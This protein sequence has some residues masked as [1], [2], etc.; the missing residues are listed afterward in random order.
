MKVPSLN[1]GNLSARLPIVQGGMGVGI[2]MS[3]LAGAVARAG[4]I[5]VISAVGLGFYRPD[6]NVDKV[7]A[8]IQ[9]LHDQIKLAREK[10]RGG[11]IG[12][13][14]M[15]AISE[16]DDLV[17]ASIEAG[18]DIIF[19][20]AGLPTDLPKL[21]EG[22]KIKLAPIISSAKA[23]SVICRAWTKRYNYTPDAIVL[24]G[25]LAGGHLGF[26]IDELE[27]AD[28]HTLDTLLKEVLEAVKP[29]EEAAG[30]SIPIIAG[31]G[32]WDGKDIAKLLTSGAA[33]VQ[34]ATRFVTTEECDASD[35]F[36]KAYLAAQSP[37]DLMLIKSPVGL[38]GRALRNSFLERVS[39]GET[40]PTRCSYNCLKTCKPREAPYCIA[41]VLINAQKGQLEDGFAFAGANAW[42]CQEIVAVQ[43]L[44]DQLEK[45]TEQELNNLENK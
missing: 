40:I 37:D 29:F 42:R 45:E 23:A 10:A 6:I 5:G 38:P 25:P 17:R 28:E 11:I 19:A 26:N 31:G 3:G 34:M 20:G 27:Q 35:D 16:F 1:I 15:V 13:N 30:R 14:I 7:E 36:K 22:S 4:G 39:E 9:A 12:V 32:V 44:M 41:N 2:S 21:I 43:E 18:A 33:A 8:N 24:E